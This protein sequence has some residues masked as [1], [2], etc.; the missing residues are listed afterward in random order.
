[1]M[2]GL[3]TARLV[4]GNAQLVKRTD[5]IVLQDHIKTFHQAEKE[6]FASRFLKVDLNALLV[7]MQTDKVRGLGLVKG[8]TP[9]T[10]DVTSTWDLDFDDL[11]TKIAQHGGAER[12]SEGV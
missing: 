12:A 8:G 4:V 5:A 3:R 1:M 10:G 9:A 11:G 7:P 2:P 6:F